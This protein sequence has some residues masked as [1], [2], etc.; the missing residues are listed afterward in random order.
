[1]RQTK[2]AC[3]RSSV[4]CIVL[5]LSRP[6]KLQ[7]SNWQ[8]QRKQQH[9]AENISNCKSNAENQWAQIHPYCARAL[10][11]EHIQ[12][13]YTYTLATRLKGYCRVQ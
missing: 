10:L 12:P 8:Q 3:L 4:C 9:C 13:M 5:T 2:Q 7:L 1:M 6:P 11:S